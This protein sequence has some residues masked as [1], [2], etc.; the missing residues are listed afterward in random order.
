[1]QISSKYNQKSCKEYL[2][3]NYNWSA[4]EATFNKSKDLYK[5]ALA[6]SS[7][8][9]KITFQQQKD[10]FIVMNSTKNRQKEKLY[11]LTHQIVLIF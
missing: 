3:K 7:F 9:H 1:M 8:K 6:E 4:D 10:K 5:N 11:D 2:C